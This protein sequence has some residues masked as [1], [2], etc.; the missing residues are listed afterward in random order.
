MKNVKKLKYK[1]FTTGGCMQRWFRLSSL[2]LVLTAA[3]N[4]AQAAYVEVRGSLPPGAVR[5][6]VRDTVYRISGTY[7]IGGTLLIEPG[8]T[9]EFMPNGRLVDSTGGRIIADGRASATY[10][11]TAVN[12]LVP[13]YT[14]Y[15]DLSYFGAAGVVTSTI[16]TEPTIHP[17]KYS[18]I[19]NVNL[20]TNVNLQGLT[21]AAAIM[22]KAARLE[23][24]SVISAI[25]LNAWFRPT[26][27]GINVTP[28]RITFKAGDVNTFSREWGH[29]VVLPGA[30]A[31]FFRDVDFVNFRKDTTV[32][33]RPVYL[34]NSNGQIFTAAQAETANAGLLDATNGGGG[35]ITTFSSRTW[36]VGCNFRNNMSRFRGGAIQIL[37][38]PA[39]TY[40]GTA[41][42][43]YPSS[44][45]AALPTYP[46][47]VN[48]FMTSPVTG[49][50]IASGLKIT[51]YIYDAAAETMTDVDR[52]SHDDARLALYLGRIRQSRF[53]GNYVLLS[54]VDTVRVGGIRVVTDADRAATVFANTNRSQKNEAF[55]GAIYVSGRTPMV[56]GIG[57]NDFQGKDTMEFN[58]NYV[59]NRQSSTPNGNAVSQ[60]ARGGAIYVGN[61][62][63]VIF[64]GR[65]TTNRTET[66]YITTLASSGAASVGNF[67]K[68]GAIYA[69]TGAWQIQVRG[70]LDNNPPTHF[71]G[72]SS[73]RGG[74]I[75]VENGTNDN[76]VSPWIGGS[77]G[78]INARNYGFNIKFR[79]NRASI[80]GGAVYTA[81]NMYM[82]GAGGTSGPLWIYGTNYGV[83][84]QNNTA[85]FSG[86]A[87]S[88]QIPQNLPIARRTL[89]FVRG[90]FL[91]N[92]V[93]QVAANLADQVRGGGALYTIN[94]DLNVV[95]G[96]E[97][98]SNKVWNGNGGA[99]AVVTPDTLTRKRFMVTDMDNITYDANGT[100][101]S[102]A[103]RNDV[104]TFQTEQPRADERMLTRFYDNEA[105]ANPGRQGSGTTQRGDIKITHPGTALREN[106][107][108]LGGALY[109][110]DSIRVRVDTFSFDRV[111][112]QNNVAFS[113][114]GMYSDNYDLKLAMA[115]CL[116]TGNKA[117]STLGRI[118]DVVDGP[119]VG[120]ANAASSDLAGAV[121]F[122]EVTGPLPWSTYSYASN[123]IYDNDARFIIRLPDAQDTK[124]V[125]AGTTGIGFG[126]VDTLRGNYWG[127]TEANV[128]TV[129]PQTPN[130][131]SFGRVQE[132][133]FIAGNGKTHMRFVRT[134]ST[135][136]T[137][138]GPFESDWRYTYTPIAIGVIPDTLLLAGRI[139]DIFDK[140]TDIKTADY[141]NR[142]MSPIED[143]AVG[144]APNLDIYS[145][146]TQPSYLKYVK[147]MTRNPYDAD[148]HADIAAV[149]T[150]FVGNH[151]IG[152]PVFLESRIDYSGSAE[153][154]NNDARSINESI[155]FVINERTGDFIRV[156]M[157]QRGLTDSI[158][159]AT[160]ELVPD[161]S[162]GGDPNIRRAYEGLA[163]YGT[164]AT[165]LSF[166]E[167]NAVAE[168]SSALQG[169][170]WEGS[171]QLGELGGAN[172]RL[173]NRPA[174]PT[175]NGGSETYYAGERYRALP[176]R[177][178]DQVTV[179]SRTALWSDG[180]VAGLL[181]GLTFT[182]GNN[183]NPP[184]FTGAADTLPTSPLLHPEYRNRVFVTENRLYTP[185]TAAQ[186]PRGGGNGSWFNEPPSYPADI[187]NQPIPG[188]DL[189]ERDSIFSITA[190]D[191]NKFY[192]PRVVRDAGFNAELAYFWDIK[193]GNSGLR[194]WLRDTLIRANATNN[195]PSWG[196]RGYRMFRGRPINP[197]IV[198]GGELVEV[199]AKNFPPSVELVDS[200][201]KN[202]W[203]ESDI[204][205]W[206]YIYPSY[207]H[208]EQYDNASLPKD[209]Q[210]PSNTNARYLQQDTVNFGWLD[211]TSYQFRIHVVDSM[212]RFIWRH[213]A[214]GNAAFTYQNML[215]GDITVVLD[216]T[217]TDPDAY[218]AATGT[219]RDTL[220]LTT[221]T[222]R[223]GRKFVDTRTN[224]NNILNEE[225]NNPAN[226]Y[227]DSL[228]IHFV[229]N[230]TDSLR[231]RADINTDDEFEDAAAVD[232]NRAVVKKYGA[233]DFRYGKTAYGF[234]STSVRETP[235]ETSLD[236]IVQ[237]RPSW[238]ATRFM[239]KYAEPSQ[240]SPF[241]E[242][243]TTKGQ[244][245]IRI[246]GLLA[247]DLL[248]PVNDFDPGSPINGDMNVDTVMSVLVNDGH[249]GINTLT[250]RLFVNVQPRLLDANLEDAIEDTDYNVQLT[251]SARRIKVY[252]PN[253]GQVQNYELIYIDEQRD[254]VAVDPYFTEA[255]QI[256]FD[257]ARKSTP[258]WLKINPTSG[259]LYGKPT[260]T[261][262][263]YSDTVV[264]VTV[265]V[266]DAGGLRD[267]KTYTLNVRAI[268]HKPNLLQSPIIRC[269]EAGREYTDKI[270]VTDIDLARK[271]AGNEE[272]TFTVIE[273]A[274]SW[275]FAPAK[276]S[277]PIADTQ[278][279]TVSTSNLQG[280]IE[281]GR[282]KVRI[283]VTDRQGEKDTLTYSVAVSAQ[284][285]FAADVYIENA[286]GGWQTLT[287]G[288][289]G[290]EIAT[291]GDEPATFG[292]L[293]SN[294]CEYELP[295][296]PFI[297]VFDARW[298]IPTRNGIIRNVHPF[299]NTPG[300]SI[301]QGRFQAGGENGV[302]S[303]YYP[304]KLSWCRNQIPT[305]DASNPGSYYIRDD[306]SNGALFAY[307]MKTGEGRSIA[308]VQHRVGGEC[309]TLV[310]TSTSIEGFIIVYDFTTDVEN[311]EETPSTLAITG[312]APNPF[313]TSTAVNFTVPTTSR[314]SVD[315]YDA[316]GNRVVTLAN[317]VY[318]TG[319][320]SVEWNG[321]AN[322]VVLP[323][324]IYTVRVSD[325]TTTTSQQIVFVR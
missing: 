139:Y 189:Y 208:A 29:I 58:S 235:G 91:N 26:G 260:V 168:D 30:G 185:I 136:P 19:F 83:E 109:I 14:G 234:V 35:A 254:S 84:F 159:R 215:R 137:E 20:G 237:A 18:T 205:R 41:L 101:V 113:G 125:L 310:I 318:N 126:G 214:T 247:R 203:S 194:Y 307:N 324:G 259:L 24:G 293:D 309:D 98:R 78:I 17:S 246:D 102:Y 34:A 267:I 144:I 222:S 129:L 70:N 3:F 221:T 207:F 167:D 28:G 303:S 5:V 32:D 250:R 108:G 281:N 228:N 142:R 112:M 172:F 104:F 297:D 63:S 55:G 230:L 110:L 188:R 305:R 155:F 294:Y 202:N 6:F 42:Q 317:E 143:F 27:A 36:I 69:S 286:I 187:T 153:I 315:I 51:D 105:Y 152:Y 204:A 73:G 72:N 62:T 225:Y 190:V 114:A 279:V 232:A 199:V 282:I 220:R 273:P 175:S 56:V 90:H 60:G 4:V 74:A 271:Q 65:Y 141:S 169:R 71:I 170:R 57:V 299:S 86:G 241:G 173:G 278:E 280:T 311:G 198:P 146:P 54:D 184:V 67:S 256:V 275:T 162:N 88:V 89:R 319:A 197:Y 251:D 257:A 93:G 10:N 265:L 283:E 154:S 106:G 37:Q 316:I 165:L 147:R 244:I 85:N 150:E 231:F 323:N 119:L 16:S 209:Q 298:T 255:G 75:F 120:A 33:N 212:P 76:S 243:F 320:Y 44:S 118:Q 164:G 272:L 48:P 196:A 95:K 59:L 8:T 186:S 121:L 161:S 38:A 160:V 238:M 171:T 134:G 61:Q 39:D 82:Y 322:G 300:E 79:D 262:L 116:I 176:V 12:P 261:D 263:P 239:R 249:G 1:V 21:P 304:V 50:P 22:Y 174:L 270:R 96:V 177:D 122:G 308:S 135:N 94:A 252:D 227:N 132:T 2:L 268:N 289:S 156:N 301:Y 140:G 149:Q 295:P 288:V 325:G 217:T 123:S 130:T 248:K 296:V 107:T 13:P 226:N 158:Y 178:G 224:P 43:L 117:T 277:S 97:F 53:T 138:Q 284:T 200:L 124:G 302:S 242:D 87:I 25:R 240:V 115:R 219:Y 47:T 163:T 31:A 128:N 151:P 218:D 180:V 285:R 103:P 45:T 313:T 99:I 274:G 145:D 321:S 253:F 269:V 100:A 68:G 191:I 201:R 211:S 276:L 23:L 127:R 229:A 210:T 312:T 64:A 179:V 192:D 193:T 195:N 7:T 258:K 183:T 52:Q 46:A 111:R 292:R 223:V 206:V 233:W 49:D 287:F 182:V 77:D 266:T 216:P 148:A 66:P 157:K 9:V 15:D 264:N 92:R 213:N 80:D 11:A 314:V 181:G 236:D 290:T 40:S 245:D 131:S 166:L 133:F 306:Q 81:R 291:R